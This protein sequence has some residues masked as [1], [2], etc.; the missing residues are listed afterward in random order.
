MPDGDTGV[1]ELARLED[2][3]WGMTSLRSD[4]LEIVE[5]GRTGSRVQVTLVSTKDAD[6]GAGG[7]RV[8]LAAG[9]P[10]VSAGRAAVF[11]VPCNDNSA[12]L[13]QFLDAHDGTNMR[14]AE[15][16]RC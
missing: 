9:E 1:F 16:W 14:I 8:G 7:F 15:A 5:V 11:S 4:A 12:M 3:K 2:G 13:F 6:L 10:W